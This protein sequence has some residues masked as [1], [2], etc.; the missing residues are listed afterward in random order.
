MMRKYSS[1]VGRDNR[2]NSPDPLPSISAELASSS[3]HHM[4][5]PRGSSAA[6]VFRGKGS[7]TKF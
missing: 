2:D 5:V 6:Q 4:E 3:E 7:S 1:M